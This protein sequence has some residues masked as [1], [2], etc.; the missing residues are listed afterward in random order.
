MSIYTLILMLLIGPPPIVLQQVKELDVVKITAYTARVQETDSTP[1]V[2][3]FNTGVKEGIIALSRDLE[4]KHSLK[5]GDRVFL[6][7]FTNKKYSGIYVFNDR[8]HKRKRNQVDIFMNNLKKAKKVGVKN[9]ARLYIYK[10][11]RNK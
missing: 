7:C 6:D 10:R 3:A 5:G 8:M 1:T 9:K 2:T 4:E 11:K